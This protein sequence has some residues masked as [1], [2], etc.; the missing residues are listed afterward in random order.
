MKMTLIIALA[1]SVVMA[2][3]AHR[4]PTMAVGFIG[5]SITSGSF[6]ARSP[7]DAF[8]NAFLDTAVI[9]VNKA[10]RG[11]SSRDWTPGG[12]RFEEAK[13]AFSSSNVRI[14]HVM[15]GT[16][17][18]QTA[19][20]TSRDDYAAN[21]RA[22]THDLASSGFTVVVSCPPHLVS[23]TDEYEAA[24]QGRVISYCE[25]VRSVIDNK[26]IFAGDIDTEQHFLLHPDSIS[27]DGVHPMQVYSDHLGEAWAD[28]VRTLIQ[29]Q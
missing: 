18:A 15:L 17:D 13:T 5:D 10:K 16:N 22:I 28:S 20:A 1:T 21:L 23:K 27:R 25:A 4:N 11:T 12:G 14:V 2:A 8:A 26:R 7:V 6:V 9:T 24:S 29:T 3:H 19:V